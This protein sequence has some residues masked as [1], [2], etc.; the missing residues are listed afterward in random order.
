LKY[1]DWSRPAIIAL[2]K[3]NS[4]CIS[5]SMLASIPR[6]SSR[7]AASAPLASKPCRICATQAW[8]RRTL[9]QSWGEASE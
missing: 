1:I 3:A 5:R 8:I 7:L 9:V 6:Y 4:R 2:G